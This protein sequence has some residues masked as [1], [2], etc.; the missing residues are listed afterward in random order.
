[1]TI[2]TVIPARGGS[3]GIPKK[4]IYP[5]N[6]KPLLL[7]TIQA[8]KACKSEMFIA[9]STD[10]DEI[11]KLASENDIYTIKRPDE[12]ATDK[13]SS[14]SVLI[15][16]L[17]YIKKNHDREFEYVITAQ[18]TT[19]FRQPATID[20]FIEKFKKERNVFNAQLTLHED[21]T[22][23]W[24]KKNDNTFERLYPDA[25]RRRQD[26]NPLYV[27]NSYLYITESKTLKKTKNV[28][29]TKC[30][31]FIITSDEALDINEM[32]DIEEAEFILKRMCL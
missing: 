24:I 15:H 23:F 2:L 22:D 30:A 19:P 20:S 10:S 31:G 9:V 17:D 8:L 29:G 6:G 7:Y 25:P 1:M 11:I 3:K 27:E 26:R 28:L 32:K 13:A 18:P 21:Y 16:A 12:L 14:E 4:N 5:L